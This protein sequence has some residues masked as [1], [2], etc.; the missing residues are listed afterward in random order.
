MPVICRLGGLV[1]AML[2]GLCGTPAAASTGKIAGTVTEAAS[3]NPVPLAN[4]TVVDSWLGAT[5]DEQGHFFIL[6][7]PPGIYAL[8]A[9]HVGYAP[10]TL[11]DVRVSV[12]LTTTVELS[13]TPASVQLE[14]VVVPAARPLVD[15]NATN[16]VRIVEGEDLINLPLRG[17]ADVLALQAGVV[18]SQGRFHVRGSRH[19]EVG[20]YFEG[21]SVRNPVTGDSAGSL[22]T[23]AVQEIL[24][25][26]GGVNAE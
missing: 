4:V 3:A 24:L 23:E 19:D 20:Y 1:F 6:N 16:A 17:V 22:I 8:Q 14:G 10:Y 21:G 25:Q 11:K 13:L 5:A 15:K 2:A 7:L 12:D 18:E 9:S 26:A